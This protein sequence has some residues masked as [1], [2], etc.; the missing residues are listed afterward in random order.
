MCDSSNRICFGLLPPISLCHSVKM[1]ERVN[2]NLSW[3]LYCFELILKFLVTD[4][5]DDHIYVCN[6]A[7][8]LWNS[9]LQRRLSL[10]NM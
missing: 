10:C 3:H 7:M 6:V 8:E 2:N 1:F 4:V 5:V 9:R